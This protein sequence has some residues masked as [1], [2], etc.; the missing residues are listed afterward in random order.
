[1][2]HSNALAEW[3]DEGAAIEHIMINPIIDEDTNEQEG[4]NGTPSEGMDNSIPEENS[5]TSEDAVAIEV[6]DNSQEQFYNL[7]QIN[8]ES[9]DQGS[10]CN[11]MS[12]EVDEG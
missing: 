3:P 4:T 1:M 11:I 9:T 6:D 7:P 10:T 12:F 5:I 2:I 8:G